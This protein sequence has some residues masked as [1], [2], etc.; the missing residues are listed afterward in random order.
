MNQ[1]TKS[2][3]REKDEPTHTKKRFMKK[4]Q[5]TQNNWCSFWK[6]LEKVN[7]PNQHVIFSESFENQHVSHVFID[8]LYPSKYAI[9]SYPLWIQT[10]KYN[11]K[12]GLDKNLNFLYFESFPIHW[13][14]VFIIENESKSS[15]EM[16]RLDY[17]N[18]GV[19]LHKLQNLD[20]DKKQII[21]KD[22][23]KSRSFGEFIHSRI[24]PTL[25]LP[26]IQEYDR[27]EYSTI[28]RNCQHFANEI[29]SRL[30]KEIYLSLKN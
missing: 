27:G 17:F 8:H 7:V 24:S 10:L 29:F 25:L 16:Y 18:E 23:K 19:F 11:Q 1:Y 3:S 4:I 21:V 22:V 20:D 15:K 12:S 6:I 30:E 5:P 26:F 14:I 13:Y 28:W 9:V 2:H